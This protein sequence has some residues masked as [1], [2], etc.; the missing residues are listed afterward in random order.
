MWAP[1]GGRF[2]LGVR[3]VG[4]W[5]GKRGSSP[6]GPIMLGSLSEAIRVWDSVVEG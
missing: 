1:E 2:P 4:S 6:P 3:W 5:R